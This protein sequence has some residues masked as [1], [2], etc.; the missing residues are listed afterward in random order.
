MSWFHNEEEHLHMLKMKKFKF[1]LIVIE[2]VVLCYKHSE[3]AKSSLFSLTILHSIGWCIISYWKIEWCF[4]SNCNKKW[5]CFAD[6]S[7]PL[8]FRIFM[9]NIILIQSRFLF[10][11]PCFRSGF[12]ALICLSFLLAIYLMKFAFY[13][14]YCC[15]FSLCLWQ[16]N[17]CEFVS[18]YDQ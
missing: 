12:E 8:C 5:K 2:L 6:I 17:R 9:Q 3:T 7:V 13:V 1:C 18:V 10:R 15:V 14:F 11:I 4:G 16:V